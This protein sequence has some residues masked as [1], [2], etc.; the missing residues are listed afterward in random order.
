MPDKNI[1]LPFSHRFDGILHALLEPARTEFKINNF[2]LLRILAALQVVLVHSTGHFQLGGP[3]VA[4]WLNCFPGV[5]IFFVISGYLVSASFE[6]QPT[7]RAYLKNRLLRICPGLWVCVLI[8][9]GIVLLLGFRPSTR[10]DYLWLPAQLA[11]MIF[12]PPFLKSFGFG[13]YN[14]SLWTIP[15]ELQF[16][17]AL[18]IVYKLA[19]R[20]GSRKACMIAAVVLFAAIRLGLYCTHPNLGAGNQT[21]LEKLI[22]YSFVPYFS[23]FLL[24]VTFQMFQIH[25]SRLIAGKALIWLPVYLAAHLLLPQNPWTLVLTPLLLGVL[26]ISVAYTAPTAAES[27]LR[28]EDI[29]YGVYIYH[30][31][32]INLLLIFRTRP[33]IVDLGFVLAGS[34][35]VGA[36]S[37]RFV[38]KPFLRKK[39]KSL[40]IPVNHEL[41]HHPLIGNGL[42]L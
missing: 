16:Y 15:V 29:S 25:R 26:V 38:E 9:A 33:S 5:P 42:D 27:I 4:R 8:T 13:S 37:W 30:A 10:I 11:G 6:R 12:T 20:R 7:V 32:I 23:L 21:T 36:L 28:G 22:F 41:L 2:D 1:A 39:R 40:G 24:G 34:A 17:L 35:I 3:G 31:L 18:P 14:G 19:S